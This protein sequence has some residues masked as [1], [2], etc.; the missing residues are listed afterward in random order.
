VIR[1]PN[2]A[3]DAAAVRAAVWALDPR[4]PVATVRTMDETVAR[5]IV[6]FTFT[7]LTLGIAAGLA[8]VLGTIGLYGLL[9]Y[10]VTLRIREIG[11]R[12]ALGAQPGRVMRAVVWQGVAIVGIGLVAGIAGAV[13]LTRFLSGL[14]YDTQ[15]L[16]VTTFAAMSAALLAVAALASYVP[17]RRA[18]SVSPLESLRSG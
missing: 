2:V 9:S 5:S 8:L 14:L 11:V 1:G 4:L 15:P 17:A 16:D 18:A 12:L 6:P 7:M 10:A 3:G 13:G